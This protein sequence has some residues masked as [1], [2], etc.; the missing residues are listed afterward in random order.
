MP[1]GACGGLRQP[2]ASFV[3]PA[4]LA[5]QAEGQGLAVLE[6]GLGS[7]TLT[8]T[9]AVAMGSVGLTSTGKLYFLPLITS[10]QMFALKTLM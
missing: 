2:G 5:D 4:G 8:H 10:L 1:P 9:A 6:G 3:L 7:A